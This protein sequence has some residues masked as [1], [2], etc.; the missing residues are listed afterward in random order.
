MS[1]ERS[2][3]IAKLSTALAIAQAGI[4]NAA[5][6]KANPFFKSKYADLA[7]VQE[8]CRPALNANGLSILQLASAA[9]PLVTVKTV[10]THASG[11]WI[12]SDLTMK[13]VKDDPQG[14]GSCIT[15]ARRYG[16]A[17]MVGVAA[18]DDDGNAASGRRE[19]AVTTVV[20]AQRSS[21]RIEVY[22]EPPKP[23]ATLAADLKASLTVEPGST[24]GRVAGARNEPEGSGTGGAASPGQHSPAAES[25]QA[26][27]E[28]ETLAANARAEWR[29]AAKKKTSQCVPSWWDSDIDEL[30]QRIAAGVAEDVAIRAICE[31][32]TRRAE[33]PATN[34]S[35]VF[36]VLAARCLGG[37]K[38]V[39]EATN[40]GKKH[41]GEIAT[42]SEAEQGQLR[43]LYRV[44]KS[45]FD[46]PPPSDADA[47]GAS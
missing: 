21:S 23:D 7:S 31:Q 30:A 38:N 12:A 26:R 27:F 8:A 32:K 18:D 1:F 15:Y 16:L 25:G 10:L 29:K 40:W 13:A 45:A 39:H 20:R 37:F 4:I 44:A 35:P 5:K 24:P 42:L 34:G 36:E 22:E 9:G 14:I 43:E 19:E 28:R 2:E 33:E 11:E 6:D 41:A 46:P 47:R 3:S 17:S